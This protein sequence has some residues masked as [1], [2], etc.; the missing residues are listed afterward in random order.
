M[1][2]I[3]WTGKTWNPLVGCT[4]HSAGCKGCYAMGEAWRKMH[5]PN[6]KIAAKF[7]G[8][9]KM[10]NGHPVWTGRIN[11]SEDALTIPLRRRVPTTWFVNSLS[12][13]FHQSVSDEQIDRVF[14]IMALCPQHR[15]Q[16]LTKRSDRMREY[17][18]SIDNGDGERF[19][20]FRSAL[21]EGM[22]QSIYHQRTGDDTV[23]EWL[24]VHLPLPN[25]WLGV[26]VEDQRSANERVPDLLA[27][28]ATVR[29]LSCEPLI[30]PVDLSHF[31]IVDS[32]GDE[33]H[34]NPLSGAGILFE[35]Q[36]DD[37]EPIELA[38]EDPFGLPTTPRI[39]W[40]ICGGESGKRVRPMHPDWPRFLRDQCAA[41]GVPFFFKQWGEHVATEELDY[42][43]GSEPEFQAGTGL[44]HEQVGRRV[45]LIEWGGQ[46]YARVGK[47]AAGR[48][49]DGVLHD[50]MPDA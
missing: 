33:L 10:V 6:P 49:L 44:E 23:D 14:A 29:F 16:V 3:E 24:A 35:H 12:D 11:F 31:S 2:K 46:T 5:H 1:S 9:A 42:G 22:A 32:D 36:G 34:Y 38:T 15:F 8:T 47:E 4:I 18:H 28:P 26:S 13:L 41:A 27:T 17:M 21:I 40:V 37:A 30:G 50:G 43:T 19:E 45:P 20:G 7:A 48:L 25:V 39:G